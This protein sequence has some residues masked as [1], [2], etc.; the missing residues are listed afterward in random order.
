MIDGEMMRKGRKL[1]LG[2]EKLLKYL[3]APL[4][5]R[6]QKDPRQDD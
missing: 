3:V 5:S 4:E 1:R 6:R 2:R